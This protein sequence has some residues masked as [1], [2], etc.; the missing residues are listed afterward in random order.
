MGTKN[1]V[2][3][4]TKDEVMRFVTLYRKGMN[5]LDH[6]VQELANISEDVHHYIL[7][8]FPSLVKEY[9]IT[10]FTFVA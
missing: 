2:A 4:P 8:N 7:V 3:K 9:N 6:K 5:M 1:N 10:A